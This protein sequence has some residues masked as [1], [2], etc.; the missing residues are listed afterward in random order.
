MS[1][2]WSRDFLTSYCLADFVGCLTG[3]RSAWK[4]GRPYIP[5]KQSL[6]RQA[7]EERTYDKPFYPEGRDA[8]DVLPS[9]RHLEV[10]IDDPLE[11]TPDEMTEACKEGGCVLVHRPVTIFRFV[12]GDLGTESSSESLRDGGGFHD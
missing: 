6:R 8:A 1:L 10:R 3:S 12:D 11:V 4:Y 5:K 7:V 9:A 2:A